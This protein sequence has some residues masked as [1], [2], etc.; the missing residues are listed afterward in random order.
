VKVPG[1]K[2]YRTGAVVKPHSD[3]TMRGDP[4]LPEWYKATYPQFI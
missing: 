4:T 2:I 3:K 1:Y